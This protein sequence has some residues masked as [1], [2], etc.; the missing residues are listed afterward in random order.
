LGLA[1]LYADPLFVDAAHGDYRL[2]SDS[3]ARKLGIKSIDVNTCGL[4]RKFPKWLLE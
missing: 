2:K 4:S 3:P 1:D